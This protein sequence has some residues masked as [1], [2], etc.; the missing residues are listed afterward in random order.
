MTFMLNTNDAKCCKATY[1]K[2]IYLEH[3]HMAQLLQVT[4]KEITV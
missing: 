4:S 3:S 2:L 1:V